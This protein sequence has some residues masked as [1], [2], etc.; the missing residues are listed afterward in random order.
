M[1]RA[2]IPSMSSAHRVLLRKESRDLMLLSPPR[3]A[4]RTTRETLRDLAGLTSPL[5]Q[6]LLSGFPRYLPAASILR[7]RR[8]YATLGLST[9]PLQARFIFS[10]DITV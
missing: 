3:N 6:I 4:A 7:R 10:L 2:K 9:S 8:A 1:A 5:S